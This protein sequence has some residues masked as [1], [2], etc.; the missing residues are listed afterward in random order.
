[1]RKE[2]M[3]QNLI[4][5]TFKLRVLRFALLLCSPALLHAAPSQI[6]KHAVEVSPQRR[7]RDLRHDHRLGQVRN[8]LGM[9]SQT[10]SQHKAEARV[11]DQPIPS[12]PTPSLTPLSQ[13]SA[14]SGV[15]GSDLEQKSTPLV[16]GEITGL[17]G[18]VQILDS[19][20]S[21]LLGLGLNDSLPCGAWILSHTG[22]L[23]LRHSLG[24][25]FHVGQETSIQ[26]LDY[27]LAG[28]DHV[29]VFQ[30]E[31]Y[32]DVQGTQPEIRIVSSMSRVRV[33]EAQLILIAGYAPDR[34][35]LMVLK[36]DAA[37]ENRFESSRSISVQQGEASE[38]ALTSDRVLPEAPSA[39]AWDT[40]EPKFLGLRI[41]RSVQRKSRQIVMDRQNRTLAAQVITH[42][43]SSEKGRGSP[44]PKNRK[45]ASTRALYSYFKSIPSPD[46]RFLREHF[47]DSLTG[48]EKEGEG[49]FFQIKWMEIF[50]G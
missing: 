44:H 18:D 33:Q 40:L 13:P 8:T 1:M 42:S 30:G 36:E 4:R 7:N 6:E 34:T 22:W 15:Q 38:L 25:Y 19:T 45:L 16:C 37:F 9:K 28:S 43:E 20:R 23:A 27:S 17:M 3:N 50:M 29:T 26:L 47:L 41:P 39:V 49:F 21:R 31:L 10:Q 5:T 14:Q 32:A 46:D 12:S 2:K 35:Q 48:G 11:P 24:P